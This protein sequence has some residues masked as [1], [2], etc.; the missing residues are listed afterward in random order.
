MNKE[1]ARKESLELDARESEMLH[2]RDEPV[3]DDDMEG[4]D[5][6]D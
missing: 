5:D 4:E 6:T 2:E 3:L 1:E